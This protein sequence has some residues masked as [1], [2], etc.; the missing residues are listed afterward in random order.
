M[1]DR[2][3]YGSSKVIF[4][5]LNFSKMGNYL[6]H[7]FL[8][9]LEENFPTQIK[10]FPLTACREVCFLTSMSLFQI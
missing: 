7:I 9:F 1:S 5:P 2:G 10:K 4:L 8:L 6:P 3:D